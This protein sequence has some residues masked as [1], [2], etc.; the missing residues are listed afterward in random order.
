MNRSRQGWGAEAVKVQL[1]IKASIPMTGAVAGAAIYDYWLAQERLDDAMTP[2][3][4]RSAL[5][6]ESDA[7]LK[8][9]KELQE[10]KRT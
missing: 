4:E 8:R 9:I 7:V 6:R 2:K 10:E 5:T 1:A 3:T